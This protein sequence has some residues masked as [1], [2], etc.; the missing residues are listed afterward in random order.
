MRRQ[1]QKAPPRAA[2]QLALR[3]RRAGMSSFVQE[4]ASS[5]KHCMLECDADAALADSVCPYVSPRARALLRSLER[6]E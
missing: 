5:E 6:A 1:R 4:C 2:G 3:P